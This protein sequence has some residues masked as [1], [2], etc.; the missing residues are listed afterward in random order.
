MV[1]QSDVEKFDCKPL[2]RLLSSKPAVIGELVCQ[3]KTYS[4]AVIRAP[5]LMLAFVLA[6]VVVLLY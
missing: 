6:S 3:G 5:N 1:V 2:R 4:F